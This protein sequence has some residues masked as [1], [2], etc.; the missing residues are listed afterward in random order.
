MAKR[1]QI[2]TSGPPRLIWERTGFPV[3]PSAEPDLGLTYHLSSRIERY[4][5]DN[6]PENNADF[7]RAVSTIADTVGR[8]T[9]SIG[10]E[11]GA[12]PIEIS[13]ENLPDFARARKS[14]RT[15]SGEI[16]SQTAL[17]RMLSFGLASRERSEGQQ[18]V[19]AVASA[20]G[21]GCI[22]TYLIAVRCEGVPRGVYF[23]D[24]ESNRLC[25]CG[26][27][28]GL[29]DKLHALQF[30]IE[31]AQ[32]RKAG[33]ILALVFVSERLLWKYGAR[34]YRFGCLEAGHMMHAFSLG[35]SS[36]HMEFC[37]VGGFCDANLDHLLGV[38][39]VN[40]VALYMAVF[41]G[42]SS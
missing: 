35:A 3:V 9:R 15:Y 13:I 18:P 10:G 29:D 26:D 37:P 36:A 1:Y 32:V 4:S 24:A 39:G 5:L 30:T 25:L 33:G 23:V 2:V 14:G 21:L 34:S 27:A 40:E 42:R 7:D 31:A 17:T 16:V 22:D 11:V 41:G 6:R 19:R 28:E 38:D 20:G 12:V 8:P